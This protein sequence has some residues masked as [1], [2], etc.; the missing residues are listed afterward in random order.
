MHKTSIREKALIAGLVFIGA[1]A[2][3]SSFAA[4]APAPVPA[5]KPVAE[6]EKFGPPVPAHLLVTVT[7][8][9]AA[10]LAYGQPPQPKAKPM[11]QGIAPLSAEDAAT[12][13]KIFA[14]Q[15]EGNIRAADRELSKLKDFR[16]RGHVL[17][18]RYMHP[19]AYKT[20]YEELANWLAL[21]NDYPGADKIYKMAAKRGPAAGLA[22]PTG[23]D[24]TIRVTAPSVEQGKSYKATISRTAAQKEQVIALSKSVRAKASKG[25]PAEALAELNASSAA[26]LMDEVE[27]DIIK[28][29]I[30]AGYLYS[31]DPAKAASLAGEALKRSGLH[32]PEAGW[33]AG[34]AAW[35]RD[36]YAKAAKFFEITARSPYASGWKAAAGSYWAARSHMRS[37]NVREVS[38][39]LKRAASHPRTF[40]GLIATRTLGQDFNFNWNIPAFNEDYRKKLM[41]TP[42][43]FRA[44]ALIAAGQTK[45]AEAELLRINPGND[46]NLREAMLAYAGHAGLPGLALKLGHAGTDEDGAFYDAALYPTGPWKPR[47]GYKI[48]PALI[49]AIMRQESKFDPEAESRSGAKGL[50]QLMPATAK[51]VATKKER[52]QM[53]D[54]EMNLELGQRYLEDLLEEKHVKGDLFSLLIAYNAGPGNLAKWKKEFKGMD[55]PLLFIESIPLAETRNYVE[56]V[57][58]NYWIYRLR[59]DLPTPTLDAVAS[60]KRASYAMDFNGV[61]FKLAA[62]E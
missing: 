24:A 56:H 36:D 42:S 29:H 50:M 53:N 10:L 4:D 30:A 2:A 55:D 22:K 62:S 33:I 32:V 25:N 40:Y 59:E 45:L 14:Y 37:G 34:L 3:G 23:S 61:A 21:Y 49:H 13:K 58:S 60:G 52:G 51:F 46:K 44:A 31:G 35:R 20:S 41:T 27:R 17:F 38:P 1:T 43:G 16:L 39:W 8:H 48:D 5:R 15:S 54:P 11:G 47:D 18:Q 19:T 28:S 7:D 9:I 6:A 12:Y 57:L 26:A